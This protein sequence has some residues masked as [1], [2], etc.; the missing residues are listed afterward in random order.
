MQTQVFR[1]D[2]A[3]EYQK[4]GPS[5]LVKLLPVPGSNPLFLPKAQI[6][7]LVYAIT[8]NE[9]VHLSGPTGSAKTS[10]IEALHLVPGNFRAICS[11][12][13]HPLFP[14]KVY[15]IEMA[16]YEAP[17]ELYQR[18]ALRNGT[19][20]DEESGLVRAL[21][22]AAGLEGKF[23][24]LIWLREIGRVH[25]AS[26]QG[27]L[28]DLVTKGDITLPGGKRVNA[29]G[30]AWVADSNYQAESEA[31]H[32]LVTLD[33][34]LKRRF[35]INL[36]LDYLSAEQETHVLLQLT[37]DNE[38]QKTTHDLVLHAV[39]LGQAIRRNKLEGNLQ[40]VAPP[41]I[42]G[43]LS[44]L[45][46]VHALPHLILQQIAMATLLGNASPEEQKHVAGVLNE[47]FGFQREQAEDPI[48]AGSLF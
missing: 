4:A 17:G 29:R 6:E 46:M 44:F 24:H 30:I 20:F 7:I 45:R 13:G 48:K 2:D 10:L 47:V 15:P 25:S 33:D 5:D 43:Y 31:T 42:Y 27:G 23:Y 8:N 36:T 26:V 21:T 28:L 3:R 19:T 11:A 38:A 18:R 35:T 32:T 22:E 41:T 37:G 9:I 12:L 40:S 39:R 14:L 34:A 1:V 16:T